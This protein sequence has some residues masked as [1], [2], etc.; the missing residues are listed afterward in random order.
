MGM[1]LA[2][3]RNFCRNSLV[4]WSNYALGA[5]LSISIASVISYDS[6]LVTWILVAL[7]TGMLA[8]LEEALV[9]S[10]NFSVWNWSAKWGGGL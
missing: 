3:S 6:S 8:S 10:S 7:D 9:G 5:D 4:F 1:V 2:F